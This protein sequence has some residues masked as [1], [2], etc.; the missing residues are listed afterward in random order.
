MSWSAASPPAERPR[1]GAARAAAAL[2]VATLAMLGPAGCGG[3]APVVER[4]IPVFGTLVTVEIAAPEGPRTRAALDR[5]EALYRQLDQDWRSFGPG[6][7]GRVNARLARGEAAGLS[8]R[9]A[10][11]VARALELQERSGGLF[12]PRVGRLVGLWGFR[13]FA[14]GDP[15]GP[16]AQGAVDAARDADIGRATLRLDGLRLVPSAPLELEL[17]GIAKGSALAAGAA[18]LGAAGVADALIAAGGDVIALGTRGGRP[19]RVGVRD[20]AGPGVLGTVE[21]AP[22]EAAASSGDYE[23]RY[24]AGGEVAHHVLD[25]RTGRPARGAAGA[26]VIGTDPELANVA[27]LALMVGGPDAFDDLA[28][29]LGVECALLVTPAGELRMTPAMQRRLLRP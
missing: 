16:P 28:V 10:A 17:A 1:P 12:D 11:L 25:P 15:A 2:L 20:P 27:A 4:V 3:P 26:T 14:S 9:L 6:E 8:P 7:L 22:G 21:L 23:R 29:R 5:V 18:E 19:W 24:R 13:D